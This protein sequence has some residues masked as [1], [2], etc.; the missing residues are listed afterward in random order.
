[1]SLKMQVKWLVQPKKKKIMFI[2]YWL[3]CMSFQTCTT[4]VWKTNE[5]LFDESFCP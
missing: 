3:S 5:C 2:I 1:M 4:F